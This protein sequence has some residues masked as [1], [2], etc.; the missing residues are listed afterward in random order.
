MGKYVARIAHKGKEILFMDIAN[1][2]QEEC[3][4]AWEEAKQEAAKELN[5]YL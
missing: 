5:S 2:G 4:A 3:L 1:K